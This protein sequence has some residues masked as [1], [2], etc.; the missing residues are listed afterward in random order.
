MLAAVLLRRDVSALGG[1]G[2]DPSAMALLREMAGPLLGLFLDQHHPR[3]LRRQVGHCL[4]ELCLSCTVLDGAG[5]AAGEVMAQV[6]TAIGPGVSF[7]F[8]L[9]FVVCLMVGFLECDDSLIH[10]ILD[11]H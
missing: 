7:S 2:S 5:A 9:S 1:A 3:P 4:A 10:H 11:A 8:E 6:L